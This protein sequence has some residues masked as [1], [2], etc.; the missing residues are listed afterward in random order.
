MLKSTYK[1]TH[2]TLF[3]SSLLLKRIQETESKHT[4]NNMQSEKYV[5][6]FENS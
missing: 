1:T 3:E 5:I 2:S 4:K 6:F